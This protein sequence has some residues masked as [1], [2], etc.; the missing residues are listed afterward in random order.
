[1]I[2]TAFFFTLLGFK[3]FEWDL[4]QFKSFLNIIKYYAKNKDFI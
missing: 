2:L 3:V 1:M 4:L